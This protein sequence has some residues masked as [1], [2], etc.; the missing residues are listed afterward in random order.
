ML[1]KSMG[2]QA[3]VPREQE[4]PGVHVHTYTVEPWQ[5]IGCGNT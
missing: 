1:L 4:A 3:L 2:L 5:R